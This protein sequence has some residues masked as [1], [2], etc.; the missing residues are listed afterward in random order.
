ML[1]NYLFANTA[2]ANIQ[3]SHSME[4]LMNKIRYYE[5]IYQVQIYNCEN[6][7][8]RIRLLN[9]DT[10][11]KVT[12]RLQVFKQLNLTNNINDKLRANQNSI[13]KNK[14]TTWKGKY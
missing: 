3:F 10:N 5:W 2:H 7:K 12:Y 11:T 1:N 4:Q 8:Y 13:F 14:I 6:I 9:Y